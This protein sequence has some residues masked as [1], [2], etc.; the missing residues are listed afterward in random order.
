M[1]E[2]VFI[3]NQYIPGVIVPVQNSNNGIINSWYTNSPDLIQHNTL[4]G[5]GTLTVSSGN[6]S[7]GG[8]SY[9]YQVSFAGGKNFSAISATTGLDTF[10]N[11]TS[12]GDN[13]FGKTGYNYDSSLMGTSI[14]FN[15]T[16]GMKINVGSSYALD[17]VIAGVGSW[18][19]TAPTNNRVFDPSLPVSVSNYPIAITDDD[20][21]VSNPS[22]PVESNPVIELDP[23]IS[24]PLEEEIVIPSVNGFDIPIISDLQYRFPFSIPWDLKIC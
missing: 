2:S 8:Y 6:Y 10:L 5:T 20:T 24:Y 17:D 23:S 11:G 3:T 21:I 12:V 7:K 22:I 19:D 9:S 13:L 1:C 18:S 4:M 15:P 14:P 16:D